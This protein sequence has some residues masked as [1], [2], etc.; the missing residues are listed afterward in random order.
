[1][2]VRSLIPKDKFDDSAIIK[3]KELSFKDIQPI[4]PDLLIWLQDMHWPIAI[5]VADVL[6]PFAD[7]IN[8]EVL[9]IL[10][11]NDELWMLGVLNHIARHSTDPD[12]IKAIERIAKFPTKDEVEDCVDEIAME[13]LLEMRIITK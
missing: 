12:V 8:S 9:P 1:M 6:R 3:L 10:T 13:I 2:N 7:R 5:Q 11:S 4:V